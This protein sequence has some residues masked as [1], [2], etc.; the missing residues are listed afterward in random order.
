[1]MR[2][3]FNMGS[4]VV[5]EQVDIRLI[6]KIL[7]RSNCPI[8][9]INLIDVDRAETKFNLETLQNSHQFLGKEVYLQ[10]GYSKYLESMNI[11]P[12]VLIDYIDGYLATHI[13]PIE[14]KHGYTMDCFQFNINNKHRQ[15]KIDIA[16][17]NKDSDCTIEFMFCNNHRFSFE[18]EVL[19]EDEQ[20]LG[21]YE[22]P[23]G[24]NDTGLTRFDN[25]GM[26]RQK[27]YTS[28]FAHLYSSP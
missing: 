20:R 16:F 24:Y 14:F 15:A 22:L 10:Q 28:N 18:S 13:T 26:V 12:N 1:M 4:N 25:W 9:F 17:D 6:I 7:H 21:K 23:W 2:Y 3:K 19:Y 27:I 5:R 11:F 8:T